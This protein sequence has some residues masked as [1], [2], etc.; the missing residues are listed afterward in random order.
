MVNR[1]TT[2]IAI[3]VQ[4]QTLYILFR[5]KESS[6]TFKNIAILVCPKITPN[7]KSQSHK[8]VLTKILKKKLYV[9]TIRIS[10]NA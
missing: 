1:A 2:D 8:T 10:G 9:F 5:K 7:T 6:I 4:N 3:R